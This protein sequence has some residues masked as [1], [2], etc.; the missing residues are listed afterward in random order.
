MKPIHQTNS[1]LV[2]FSQIDDDYDCF[3]LP[4][5]IRRHRARYR[6]EKI[7]TYIL[8]FLPILLVFLGEEVDMSIALTNILSWRDERFIGTFKR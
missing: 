2:K 7:S 8:K 5:R 6:C 4:P 1:D 3:Q